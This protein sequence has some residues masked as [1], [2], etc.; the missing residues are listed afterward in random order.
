MYQKADLHIH[1]TESDGDL[2]PSE[3][4]R[5]ASYLGIDLIAI[6]DHNTT[7]GI[8][9]AVSEGNNYSVKV[10]PGIELSTRHKG[11]G[12]HILG[13]FKDDRY[14]DE[15][16]IT[17]LDFINRKK[18]KSLRELFKRDFKVE[19][20]KGRVSV[21]SGIEI[22]KHFGAK[23]VL[24]HPVLISKECTREI[25]DM[26][27]DGIE[28][29]H[30]RNTLRDTKMYISLA[31]KK[32]LFYTG[33]SDFHTNKTVDFNHGLIGEV[34]LD[35]KEIEKFLKKSKLIKSKYFRKKK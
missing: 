22:L 31:K 29:K 13:Y 1:T 32:K 30:Y 33:G 23:V 19:V 5:Y 14:K 16:F 35:S 28:A 3:V 20:K 15:K 8:E 21:S 17:A 25:I 18:D 6:T 24:A 12:I 2:T 27:F 10:I 26:P 4:V 7:R 11:R 9:E 34:Y